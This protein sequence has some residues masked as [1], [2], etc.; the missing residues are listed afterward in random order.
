ME[1]TLE[2]LKAE[3][4]AQV[5]QPEVDPQTTPDDELDTP[6][7]AGGEVTPEAEGGD[8]SAPEADVEDWMKSDDQASQSAGERKFTDQDVAAAKSKLRAKL[9]TRH[10]TEIEQLQ[11]QL[12]EERRKNQQVPQ[13]G[14]KPRLEQF[15]EMEN[16]EEAFAEAIVEWKL[17]ASSAEQQAAHQQYEQQRRALEMRQRIEQRVDQHYERAQKLAEASGIS[18]EQY[19]YADRSVR[20]AVEAVFPNGGG[21]AVT[22]MLIANLKEGSEK[23][24]YHLGVNQARRTEFQNLL[25]EDPTGLMAAAH[26]GKLSAELSNPARKTSN[27]PK[28]ATQIQGDRQTTEAGR[29]LHQKYKDAH[30]SGDVQTALSL[31]RK[32]RDSGVNTQNW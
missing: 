21:E 16:P 22:N 17:K 25:K 32:A 26:L 13:L 19:Q 6:A 23:V 4:A 24:F 14:D 1:Q 9:E 31:K 18:P 30:K 8:G 5:T 10:Q 20:E 11:Q 29:A 3:N 15:Y 7:E 12:E 28:P 27:A 2:Q